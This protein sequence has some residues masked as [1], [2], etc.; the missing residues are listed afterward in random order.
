MFDTADINLSRIDERKHDP[1]CPNCESFH[2][3]QKVV[4]SERN[5]GLRTYECLKCG[6]DFSISVMA[7]DDAIPF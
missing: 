6:R 1:Q 3:A 7:E 2:T 5:S 4:P